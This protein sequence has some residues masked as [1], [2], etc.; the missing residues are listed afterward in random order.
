MARVRPTEPSS[1]LLPRPRSFTASG[2]TGRAPPVRRKC[3]RGPWSREV[4]P[5]GVSWLD[6]HGVP[7]KG[8]FRRFYVAVLKLC[9]RLP[10]RGSRRAAVHFAWYGPHAQLGA[11]LQARRRWRR[12][13]DPRSLSHEEQVHAR[14]GRRRGCGVASTSCGEGEWSTSQTENRTR[15]PT[16]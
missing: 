13:D 12:R 8:G 6:Y 14:P 2:W 15:R 5:C 4:A 3:R 7:P 1:T 11:W 16:S 10:L 9:P